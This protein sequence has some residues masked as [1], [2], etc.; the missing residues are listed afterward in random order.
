M[1]LSSSREKKHTT[2]L[3]E[4]YGVVQILPVSQFLCFS[5]YASHAASSRW[6]KLKFYD[7]QGMREHI[8]S[9]IIMETAATSINHHHKAHDATTTDRAK[10]IHNIIIHNNTCGNPVSE[11]LEYVLSTLETTAYHNDTYDGHEPA[12]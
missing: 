6:G 12:F 4:T 7:L 2:F 3:W 8:R 11:N 10:T 5:A 9:I 1:L